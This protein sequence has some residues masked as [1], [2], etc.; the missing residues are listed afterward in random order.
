MHEDVLTIRRTKRVCEGGG[1][2]VGVN[3]SPPQKVFSKFYFERL[4][5]PVA[6]HSLSANI[7]ICQLCVHDF[8]C[9][10]GNRKF[11]VGLIKNQLFLT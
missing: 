4:K 7:L 5:L 10:H 1:G 11:H 9:C 8:L 3:A 6:V 2:G